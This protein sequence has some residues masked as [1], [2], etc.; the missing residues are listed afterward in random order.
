VVLFIQQGA[1]FNQKIRRGEQ[2]K[3]TIDAQHLTGN[4]PEGFNAGAWVSALET[5]YREIAQREFPDAEVVVKID[6]QGAS[7]YSRPVAVYVD[8][9]D[10]TTESIYSLEFQIEQTANALYD[11]R[12]QEFFNETE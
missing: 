10:D 1:K 12:G 3:I 9:A 8:D 4:D 5:E 11:S 2:M 6:V 7:G